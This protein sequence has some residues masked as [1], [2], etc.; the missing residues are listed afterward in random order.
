MEKYNE[1]ES[2]END[3]I[4]DG[5]Q[6]ARKVHEATLQDWLERD[7]TFGQCH[8]RIPTL[9]NEGSPVAIRAAAGA[10]RMERRWALFAVFARGMLNVGETAGVARGAGSLYSV[11]GNSC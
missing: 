8:H 11:D 2:G 5:E 4:D 10:F 3:K 7:K 6:T 1:K 9:T